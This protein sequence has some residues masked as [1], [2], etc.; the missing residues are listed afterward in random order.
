MYANNRIVSIIE[1]DPSTTLFFREALKEFTG[2]AVVAFT[3]PILALEH[4]QKYDYAYVLVISD[5]KMA[6]LN[7]MEFLKKI[8]EYNRFVRTI[9]ITAAFR[10]NDNLFQEYTKKKI[11]DGFVQKPIGLHDFIKEVDTQLQAYEMQK[12]FPY[13]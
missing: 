12:K 8:K 1:D 10:I 2:I 4:F 5:Y 7:G 6:A 11:I 13:Q 3:D 9:L